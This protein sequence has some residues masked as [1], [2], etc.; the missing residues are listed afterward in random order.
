[1]S[2]CGMKTI[3]PQCVK[4]SV[5]A[6][7]CC[8]SVVPLVMRPCSLRAVLG[9]AVAEHWT[10]IHSRFPKLC[11]G[12]NRKGHPHTRCVTWNPYKG[13]CNTVVMSRGMCPKTLKQAE[14]GM[15]QIKKGGSPWIG[16]RQQKKAS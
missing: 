11:E 10:T 1:M 16:S 12:V 4:L 7:C 5:C 13:R 2:S 8:G 6:R 3:R 14:E 9:V 15:K